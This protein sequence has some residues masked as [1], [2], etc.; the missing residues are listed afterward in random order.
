MR[1]TTWD[2]F[3]ALCLLSGT[4]WVVT[5]NKVGGLPAMEQQGLL[6]GLIGVIALI[7]AG[8][9]VWSRAAAM[10]RVELGGIALGFFGVPVVVAE[11]AGA[12]VPAISRSALFAMVPIVVVMALATGE[13]A[14]RDER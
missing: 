4:S 7:I 10:D 8:R 3:A 5:D 14:T 6:L 13:G 1:W 11:Y 2:A 12:S 9:A